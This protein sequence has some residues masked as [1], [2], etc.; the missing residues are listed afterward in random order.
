MQLPR[1]PQDIARA[2]VRALKTVILADG[3]LHELERGY[4]DAVQRHILHTEFDLDAL[5]TIDGKELASLVPPGDFRERILR[6]AVMAALIDTEASPAE[7]AVIEDFAAALEV[8]AAPVRDLQR[9]VDQR[10]TLFRFDIVRRSF[11]GKRFEQHLATKGVRGLA[12]L[13]AAFAGF[14]NDS[15]AARYRALKSLP[16]GTLGRG[17]HDFIDRNGFGM[18]GEKNGAPEPIVF[19]DC[20]HVLAEYDTTPGEEVSVVGF[21]AGFQNY[22]PFFTML[23]VV[24]QFHLGVR[25]SPVAGTTKLAIDPDAMTRAFVRGTACTR[26]LSDGWDPWEDFGTPVTV[27]RERYNIVPRS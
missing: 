20:V 11:I 25:I 9:L 24:A 16:E 5:D 23:F 10:L 19:H 13:A 14:E 17:Y 4:I 15:I 22:D 21:Q 12:Q 6:S 27:L 3:E 8:D 2:G 18:P 26:D 1:P 7:L